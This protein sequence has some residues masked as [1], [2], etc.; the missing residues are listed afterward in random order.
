MG[1]ADPMF[2]VEQSAK[3]GCVNEKSVSMAGRKARGFKRGIPAGRRR[4]GKAEAGAEG[5]VRCSDEQMRNPK[6]PKGHAM[7]TW[8]EDQKTG[9]PIAWHCRRCRAPYVREGRSR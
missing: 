2:H 6:C 4:T 5:N 1:L 3:G 9:R 7:R 8:I